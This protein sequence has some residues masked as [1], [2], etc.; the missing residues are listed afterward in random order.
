MS[1]EHNLGHL[2]ALLLYS[3]YVSLINLP[4]AAAAAAASS[5]HRALT[6][7]LITAPGANLPDQWH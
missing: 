3:A 7:V 4:A 6:S 1:Q 5:A 2:P